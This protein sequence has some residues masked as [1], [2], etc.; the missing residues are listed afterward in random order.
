MFLTRPENLLPFSWWISHWAARNVCSRGKDSSSYSVIFQHE[1]DMYFEKSVALRSQIVLWKVLSNTLSVLKWTA[2]ALG[3]TSVVT[4][5]KSTQLR[6]YKVFVCFECKPIVCLL[7]KES[8]NIRQWKCA[9][10][11]RGTVFLLNECWPLFTA[12]LINF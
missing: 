4:S 6:N 3:G 9:F 8:V 1:P 2:S 11:L 12:N 10:S 5:S 7:I